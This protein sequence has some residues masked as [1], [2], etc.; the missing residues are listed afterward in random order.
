MK[1]FKDVWIKVY[2]SIDFNDTTSAVSLLWFLDLADKSIPFW[3]ISSLQSNSVIFSLSYSQCLLH[4]SLQC[5]FLTIREQY[6]QQE[7]NLSIFFLTYIYSNYILFNFSDDF[8]D[9]Y[10]TSAMKYAVKIVLVLLFNKIY[11]FSIFNKMTF[12]HVH[13]LFSKKEIVFVSYL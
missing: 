2:E 6:A 11:N 8:F 7:Y 12:F 1:D 10:F 13:I 3:N 5:P 4:V 9:C